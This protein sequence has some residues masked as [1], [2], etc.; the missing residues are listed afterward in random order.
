MISQVW[1]S[2]LAK[3]MIF[4]PWLESFQDTE[5]QRRKIETGLIKDE[6]ERKEKRAH[7]A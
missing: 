2:P 7:I 4:C 1:K 3:F 5:E 6:K